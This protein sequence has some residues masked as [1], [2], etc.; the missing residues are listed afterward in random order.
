[1]STA[2]INHDPAILDLEDLW[3]DDAWIWDGDM[4]TWL[5]LEETAVLLHA[6]LAEVQARHTLLVGGD[7][8]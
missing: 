3:V 8:D 2:T 6:P 4:P 1:M 5:T 7:S